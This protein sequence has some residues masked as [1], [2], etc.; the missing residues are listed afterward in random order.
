MVMGPERGGVFDALAGLVRWGLGGSV[1]GG[2]QWMSW[3]HDRDFVN[4]VLFLIERSDLEGAFNLAAPEPVPQAEFMTVLRHA[5]GRR[6]G[7]PAA[8]WMAEIGAF[9]RRS[10]TELLFK[11]RRVVPTRLMEAGFRFA[12][13]TWEAAAADLAARYRAL[14]R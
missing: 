5:L 2:K 8:K 11:S 14:A 10:D 9:V 6:I 13:P 7:L 12:F 1:A 4:A 3:I